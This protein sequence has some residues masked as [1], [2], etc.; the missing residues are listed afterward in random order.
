MMMAFAL[1]RDHNSVTSIHVD[2]IMCRTRLSL[3]ESCNMLSTLLYIPPSG[4]FSIFL[5]RTASAR[6]SL[7]LY[8]S[9]I[10]Y[11]AIAVSMFEYRILPRK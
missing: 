5:I 6:G 9:W 10:S 1:E 7:R 8:E 4:L 3:I 11:L 2:A